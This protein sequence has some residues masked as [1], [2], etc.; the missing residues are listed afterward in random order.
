MSPASRLAV[1]FACAGHFL[2]HVLTGLFLTLAVVLERAWE[3]PFDQVI[4][5]WTWG[6]LLIGLGAPAAGWLADRFG[7][8]PMMAAFFLGIGGAAVAAGLVAGPSGMAA[9]LGALGLFGAIYHPVGLSWVS[10]AAPAAT[11]GRVMGLVGI[12]GSLGVAAAAVTAGG[13]AALAGWRAALILP[14][15]LGVAL[16]LALLVAMRLDRVA[17]AG[18]GAAV[19]ASDPGEARTPI[20]VLAVLAVTFCLGSLLYTAFST[21][22]P[23]WVSESL[24]LDGVADSARIGLVVG[25]VFLAGS[26]GQL[27]GGALA[28]RWSLKWLYVATFAAKLPLLA[29]AGIIGGPGAVAIAALVVLMFDFSA[30][31]ENLLLARYSSG[32]RRGLAFGVKFAMGFVAAP[33]GVNLVSAMWGEGAGFGPFFLVL[34][35]LAAAMLAASLFLPGRA[36]APLPP[37]LAPLGAD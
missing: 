33:L 4:A 32:R 16:G 12:S 26:V 20:A 13:I 28:D 3:L 31:V 7:N 24:G 37:R 29:L 14:G 19:E 25:L 11:R 9:A 8:A 17:D 35:G 15:M 2:H 30:P 23:K 1:G 10:R 36:P 6:A 21:A 27:L 34:A 5:L 18:R 22:T